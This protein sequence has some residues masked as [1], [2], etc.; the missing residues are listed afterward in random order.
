[1]VFTDRMWPDFSAN[2]LAAAIEEFRGRD[3]RYG[4]IREQT[5][6]TA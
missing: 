5:L 6:R 4:G 1:M 2:D 3:R